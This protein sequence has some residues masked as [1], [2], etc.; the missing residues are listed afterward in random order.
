MA[1]LNGMQMLKVPYMNIQGRTPG[2][3]VAMQLR[4]SSPV[5]LLGLGAKLHL[6]LKEK[7]T[8]FRPS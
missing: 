1:D 3:I 7:K 4:P 2:R 6:F 5:S 8:L